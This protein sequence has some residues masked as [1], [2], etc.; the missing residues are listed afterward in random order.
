MQQTT[1]KG[2]DYLG[3]GQ[4]RSQNVPGSFSS[5]SRILSAGSTMWRI[6]NPTGKLKRFSSW[7]KNAERP[8]ETES[9]KQYNPRTYDKT[10]QTT[11]GGEALHRTASTE[12]TRQT[13]Q[14]SRT[15]KDQ[16]DN[17]VLDD[18][19]TSQLK[20]QV[21]KFTEQVQLL[22]TSSQEP[23]ATSSAESSEEWQKLTGRTQ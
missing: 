20:E 15:K 6:S 21:R 11:R 7:L 10:Y 9:A 16:P 8:P 4:A 3:C 12:R 23:G 5:G 18:G 17:R 22:T 1:P 2:S 19:S 14:D 13:P